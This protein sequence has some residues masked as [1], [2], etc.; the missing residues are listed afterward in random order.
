ML[1]SKLA[2]MAGL[3]KVAATLSQLPKGSPVGPQS[4]SSLSM[5][6]IAS[7]FLQI[8]AVSFRLRC[9]LV[10][11]GFCSLQRDTQDWNDGYDGEPADKKATAGGTVQLS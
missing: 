6:V 7:F 2:V 10:E 8:F 4:N 3:R 11:N 9:V 5:A 1:C